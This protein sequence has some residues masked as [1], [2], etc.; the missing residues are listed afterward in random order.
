MDFLL[1]PGQRIHIVGIGGSGMSAIAR[2]LLETGYVISGS[3]EHTNAITDSLQ[4]D[5]ATIFAGHDGPHVV[6][7]EL[8]I[9]SSAIP[10]TNIEIQTRHAFKIPVLRRRDAI[11]LITNNLRTI[12]IS[13]THGK[14][15]TTALMTHTL[16][17]A[18][19]EPSYI[20][21]GLM[22][23]TG[24]NAGAGNGEYFVIQPEEY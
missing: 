21:G 16:M 14:T 2:V 4:A 20:I 10:D 1:I 5:G 7:A 23:N 13:G 18:G 12:A 6:G 22:K 8:V 24:T 17:E 9:A 15:T 11:S 3:D 19:L